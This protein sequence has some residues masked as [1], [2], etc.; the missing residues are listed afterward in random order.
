MDDKSDCSS[1]ESSLTEMDWLPQ[2]SVGGVFGNINNEETKN[3]SNKNVE[4]GN[5]KNDE[6]SDAAKNNNNRKNSRQNTTNSFQVPTSTTPL[7]PPFSYT[8]LITTAI[9]SSPHKRMTLSDIYQWI[10]NNY[11]YYQSVGYGWK[12]SIFLV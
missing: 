9:K 1:P 3:E 5:V 10:S 6:N 12:V 4:E 8:Y 2:L 7:K 11:P